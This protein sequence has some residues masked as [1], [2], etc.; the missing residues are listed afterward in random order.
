MMAFALRLI[1]EDG[2]TYYWSNGSLSWT[3]DVTRATTVPRKEPSHRILAGV[4]AAW[5]EVDDQPG[6]DTQYQFDVHDHPEV[7]IAIIRHLAG[8]IT[9][10]LQAHAEMVREFPAIT[11]ERALNEAALSIGRGLTQMIATM[12]V[13]VSTSRKKH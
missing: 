6:Q 1:T 5:I 4:G 9:R 12:N 2:D 10:Q 3:R 13:G 7:A 8:M 11:A